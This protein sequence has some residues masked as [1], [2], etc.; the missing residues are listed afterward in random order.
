LDCPAIIPAPVTRPPN[1]V[2][3]NRRTFLKQTAALAAATAVPRSTLGARGQQAPR[4]IPPHREQIVP[5]VHVYADR[6]SVAPGETIRFHVSA[7]EA[8][9]M[10]IC[11]LG[12]EVDDPAG[13]RVVHRFAPG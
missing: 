13:D 9:Q 5:G 2:R 12:L 11:R 6:Q 10:E 4:H 3:T 8:S 1:P 7:D